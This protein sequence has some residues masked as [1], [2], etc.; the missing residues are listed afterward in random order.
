MNI[1]VKLEGIEAKQYHNKR[2]HNNSD[3]IKFY[4]MI[5]KGLFRKKN[6]HIPLYWT[7]NLDILLF[8][9]SASQFQND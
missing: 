9:I 5:R 1:S 8:N 6:M 7:L 3:V 2:H 4:R